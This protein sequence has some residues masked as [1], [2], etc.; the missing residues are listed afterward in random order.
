MY[1]PQ[2]FRDTLDILTDNELAAALDVSL[3]TL[4]HW[5]AQGQGPKY[6]RLGRGVFYRRKDITEWI[7]ASVQEPGVLKPVRPIN[8][9]DESDDQLEMFPESTD[10]PD[11][12][13]G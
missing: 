3:K 8:N 9:T 7:N 6:V 11:Y 1:P 4:K 13:S 2:H 10:D 5:R 12:P